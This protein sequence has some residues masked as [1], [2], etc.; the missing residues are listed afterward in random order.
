MA[1]GV[2]TTTS[3]TTKPHRSGYWVTFA[4]FALF[5]AASGAPTALYPRYADVWHLSAGPLTIAFGV[6]AIALLLALLILGDLSDAVGRRPVIG[7]A[8]VVLGTSLVVFIVAGGYVWLLVARVLAGLAA[9]LI[10]ASSA[11]AMLDLEPVNRPGAASLDNATGAMGGQAAGVLVSALLVQYAPHPM[12]LIYAILIVIGAVLAV[13]YLLGVDETVRVRSPY[14]IRLE[15]GVPRPA[16]AAFLA[17]LPCL[18][19]TWAIASLYMSLGPDIVSDL[20]SNDNAVLA[21]SAPALLL[22]SGTVFAILLRA[23]S[24]RS[25]ML[26]GSGVLALGSALTAVALGLRDVPIFYASVAVAGLGFGVAFSGALQTLI[27]LSDPGARA[28]L[29]ATIYVVAYLSFSV[30]AVVAGFVS[31]SLG[32]LPTSTIFSAVVAGLSLASFVATRRTTGTTS[33]RPQGP[34]QA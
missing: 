13:V 8:L 15:L 29:I 19:A 6:Y 17:A 28:A 30:P 22:V 20:L 1:E 34:V 14:V 32:L 2:P 18:I 4:I 5:L 11:A 10:T 31:I 26:T 7:G 25:R 9:G 3:N 27:A 23:R 24:P 21:V 12:T 16:M 33:T